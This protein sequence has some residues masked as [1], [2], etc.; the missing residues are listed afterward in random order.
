M[1]DIMNRIKKNS[2]IKGTSILSESQYF[3]N[4]DSVPTE[5]PALNIALS[6]SANGGVNPGLLTIAGPSKNGKTT[7]SLLMAAAYLKKYSDAVMLFYDSEF[8]MPTNYFN[9]YGIDINR[10]IH[11][12]VMNAEELKFDMIAQ[13][14]EITRDDKVI[15][16]LDSMG[17]LASKKEV[18]DAKSEN[19]VADMTRA[20]AF[21]SL[22]RM[23]TPYLTQNDI[24]MIAINHTYDSMSLFP[25]KI[26]SGGCVIEGT[27]IQTPNGAKA[28]EDFQ[29]GDIVITTMGEKEVT[30]TWNPETLISGEPE[31]FEV[32]FDDGYIVTCSADHMFLIDNGE[33]KQRWVK[34]K[35]L[36]TE[37]YCVTCC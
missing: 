34:A 23:I 35:D 27:K 13:L 1:S 7:L 3:T 28:V 8:G 19:S 36:Q 32:E 21:K 18:E 17:N 24:P 20:K 12:P 4:R 14:E 6:G 37:D 33:D 26:V 16:V 9:A 31:C 30:Y 22:F 2:K 25:Q 29:P 15:I 5:I 10:V 11:V